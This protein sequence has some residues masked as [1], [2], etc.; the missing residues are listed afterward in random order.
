MQHL[1]RCGDLS[2]EL[3]A[4]RGPNFG[5]ERGGRDCFYRIHPSETWCALRWTRPIPKRTAVIDWTSL[6]RAAGREVV[7]L[8]CCEDTRPQL[9]QCRNSGRRLLDPSRSYSI[10]HHG[11]LLDI[12]AMGS[13]RWSRYSLVCVLRMQ[14][15]VA[16]GGSCSYQDPVQTCIER[17]SL[18]DM[19]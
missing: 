2:V 18:T 6:L 7:C 1:S 10:C 3:A 12:S 11:A 14:C 5:P 17:G 13:S 8:V 19:V 4:C 15:K 9:H 16:P